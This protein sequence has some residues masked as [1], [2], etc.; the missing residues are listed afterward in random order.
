MIRMIAKFRQKSEQSP[1]DET[2]QDDVGQVVKGMMSI[3]GSWMKMMSLGRRKGSRYERDGVVFGQDKNLISTNDKRGDMEHSRRQIFKS[4]CLALDKLPRLQTAE[5]GA[6]PQGSRNDN[7][8][9]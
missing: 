2:G 7:L 8:K 6:C 1:V 4:P 5:T 9:R 3:K